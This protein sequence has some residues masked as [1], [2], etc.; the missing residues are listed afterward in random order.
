MGKVN[1]DRS[2]PAAKYSLK[3]N[4]AA[5]DRLPKKVRLALMYSDHNWSAAHARYAMTSKRYR[6]SSDKLVEVIHTSDANLR[7]NHD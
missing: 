5:Y 6:Y 3:Q 7:T 4:M 2:I 1:S